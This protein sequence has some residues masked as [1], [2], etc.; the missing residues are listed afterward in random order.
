MSACG[1]ASPTILCMSLPASSNSQPLSVC[2]RPYPLCPGCCPL[3]CCPQ[4]LSQF[5]TDFTLICHLFPGRH[6]RHLKNKFNKES[7]ANP[8]R[9]DD[10][11]KASANA[12]IS[13]YQVRVGGWVG[14]RGEGEAW[15][16]SF[17]GAEGALSAGK[18]RS[19][20]LG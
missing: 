11:L 9:V 15:I 2:H 8:T 7:K 12:T 10:A 19:A 4:A 18:L 5:G 13:S 1:A 6:R 20:W 3:L 16:R 17:T 14:W